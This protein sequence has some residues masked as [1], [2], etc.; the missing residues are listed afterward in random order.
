M[1]GERGYRAEIATEKVRT[2][3]R[4]RVRASFT[5]DGEDGVGFNVHLGL[6]RDF[7]VMALCCI[8]EMHMQ[9]NYI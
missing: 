3:G 6:N 9:K 1:G 5:W 8:C 7:M 2:E 4:E